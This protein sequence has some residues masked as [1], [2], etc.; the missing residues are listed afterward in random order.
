MR[1]SGHK[2]VRFQAIAHVYVGILLGCGWTNA[3]YW[4]MAWSISVVEL[5]TAI[6]Q[7]LV[8]KF[9]KNNGLE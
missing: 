8:A 5:V 4:Y 3:P 2:S 7:R 9:F 1:I 6:S